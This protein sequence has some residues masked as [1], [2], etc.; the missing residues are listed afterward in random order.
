MMLIK[1]TLKKEEIVMSI[2]K[3]GI[4]LAVLSFTAL[5]ALGLTGCDDSSSEIYSKPSNYEDKIVT[6]E[7]ETEEIY[8]NTLKIIYDAIHEGTLASEVLD[9][10]LFAYA[11]SVFGYYNKVVLPNGVEEVTLKQAAEEI[12]AQRNDA[13]VSLENAYAFIKAHKAYWYYNDKGEHIKDDGTVIGEKDEWTPGENELDHVTAKWEAIE[14]RIAEKMYAKATSAAYVTKNYYYEKDFLRALHE[15]NKDVLYDANDNTLEKFIIPY[16]V[17]KQ[18]VFDA[19]DS[20][21]DGNQ[22]VI[23][24]REKYQTSIL[25]EGYVGRASRYIEDEILPD[26]YN[27]LLIEQYLLDEDIASVRNSRARKINVIKI[28]KYSSFTNNADLL[29][30]ELVKEIYTLP[31]NSVTTL[32]TNAEKIEENSDKLFEKYSIIAKGLYDQIPDPEDENSEYGKILAALHQT[33]SD[34]Y[35]KETLVVDPGDHTKDINYYENTTFGD[36]VKDY[37][38]ILA[39]GNNYD[40]LK[41][42]KYSSFTSNGSRSVVEGFE[43]QK[44]DL[45]QAENIT[46]GW[47]IQ[48]STPTLDSNGEINNRLFKLSVANAK[49]ELEDVQSEDY[50]DLVASDRLQYKDGAWSIKS[51]EDLKG[52]N[53]FL[54]SINGSYFIRFDGKSTSD[55]WKNDIVYDDGSAYYV[56]QVFEAA[57]DAKLRNASDDNYANTRGQSFMDSVIDEIAKIVGET[58]N[59]STLSREHWLEKMELSYHDQVVYDYFKS[60]YP[61]LFD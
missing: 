24:H 29:V 59:Y 16:T 28:D 53:K 15:D 50:A 14:N 22:H 25:G 31:D 32:E 11:S 3:K 60:N 2:N 40:L 4:K 17:E 9:E 36:L 33:A 52:E 35:K 1:Q 26:V 19:I 23:L 13:N 10:A 54:C 58:G 8:N 61:D 5:L 42:T 57:K 45:M 34:I 27:D 56:V 51:K 18:D 47:Y 20:F 6:V 44:I 21:I 39:A 12:E 7:N 38:K 49:V 46:K 30:Q 41:N 43:Q 55:D 37:E 48:S